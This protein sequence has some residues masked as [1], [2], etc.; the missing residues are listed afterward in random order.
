[1][2]WYWWHNVEPRRRPQEILSVIGSNLSPSEGTGIAC[3]QSEE[4]SEDTASKRALSSIVGAIEINFSKLYSYT[5]LSH[6]D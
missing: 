5:T 1:M 4:L 2:H 6:S 3:N